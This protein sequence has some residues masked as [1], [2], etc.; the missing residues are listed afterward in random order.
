VRER[1]R[2]AQLLS[3]LEG[4]RCRVVEG[5]LGAQEALRELGRVQHLLPAPP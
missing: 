3:A 4:L 2:A 5:S 1:E